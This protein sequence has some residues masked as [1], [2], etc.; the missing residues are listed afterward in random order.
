MI[1]KVKR[2]VEE[3][4]ELT[5]ILTL[6]NWPNFKEKENIRPKNYNKSFM[7]KIYKRSLWKQK[8]LKIQ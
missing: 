3:N 2:M 8:K 7:E 1:N 6:P 4:S 5:F